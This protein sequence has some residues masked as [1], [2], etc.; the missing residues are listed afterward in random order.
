MEKNYVGIIRF[1]GEA[2]LWVISL[3][4]EVPFYL[5]AG[6]GVEIFSQRYDTIVSA[7]LFSPFVA[8]VSLGCRA[9][10]FHLLG[11]W[12]LK[13]YLFKKGAGPLLFGLA[14]FVLANLWVGAWAWIFPHGIA[15]ELFHESYG[16]N[17]WKLTEY[18]FISIPPIAFGSMTFRLFLKKFL[19]EIL[20]EILFQTRP[21][22]LKGSL[23]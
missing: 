14:D 16:D 7:M 19:P 11:S 3:I 22:A 6:T 20:K 1:T 21:R 5:V 17:S 23:P 9:M 13:K 12:L 18:W 4:C 10:S 15:S 2:G 8:Y